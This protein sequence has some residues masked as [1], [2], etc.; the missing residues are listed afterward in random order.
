ML[1]QLIVFGTILGALLLFMTGWL[2]YDVVAVL[3]LMVVAITGV[4]EPAQ[5]FAGFS[6]PAVI[7]VAAV[8]VISQ[9]L[10]DCGVGD[11][12]LGWM[13]R[14]GNT[15]TL[16][17][18]ALCGMVMVI[19]SF[20]NNTGA[21]AL[22]MPVAIR[23]ARSAKRPVSLFLMPLAFSALLGGMTT[24]IGT[25]TNIILSSYRRETLGRG[26]G[27]FD[28]TPVGLGVALAGVAFIALVG[29][30]FIPKREGHLSRE[31][32][33]R[34][35]DYLTEV[36]IPE[37]SR[38]VGMSLREFLAGN[39]VEV[40]VLGLVRGGYRRLVPASYE[41]L[42]AGDVLIVE[43][44]AETMRRLVE[45]KGLEL[46]GQGELE[47]EDLGS[48]GVTLVEAVVKP[49]SLLVGNTARS[50]NLRFRYGLNLLAVARQ[51]RRVGGR[52]GTISFSGGDVLLFQISKQR[53][54]QTLAALGCI[55][56]SEQSPKASGR[57]LV[58][59]GLF[60]AGIA[61]AASGL[62]HIE[63]ALS[64]TALT[65]VLLRFISLKDAYES[66][67]WS[68]LVLLAAL[69]PL[70]N[71]LENSGGAA[72]LAGFLLDFANAASAYWALGLVFVFSMLLANLINVKAAAVLMA[73]IAIGVAQG[74]GVSV[75]PFLIAVAMGCDASFMTPIGHQCNT[76]VLGPGGYKFSDYWRLGLPLSLLVIAVAIPLIIVFWPL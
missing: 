13:K 30:R 63:V 58:A 65:M 32:M 14:V 47:P 26:F 27:M 10:F 67:D 41:R 34:V 15:P 60:A 4:L 66:I 70:G 55:P 28:F 6:N 33:F 51:G 40:V 37:D 29:W 59:L 18:A 46:T 48:E 8:L 24:L 52:L 9:T 74:A 12:M 49:D 11:M 22:V 57:L 43:G 73:P 61:A 64:A 21:L 16:Q 53:M 38:S 72:L 68:V 54:P 1:E 39:D 69:L 20:I 2:R 25:P 44:D 62:L 42:R 36:S 50:L 17:V 3:A 19:S 76:L 56:L 75:D 5:V 71:A 31:A 7:T 23:M 35:K 45:S